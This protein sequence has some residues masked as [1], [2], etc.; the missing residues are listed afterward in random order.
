[1][2]TAIWKWGFGGSELSFIISLNVRISPIF[3]VFLLGY[4]GIVI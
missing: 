3:I 2:E 4:F 1:M